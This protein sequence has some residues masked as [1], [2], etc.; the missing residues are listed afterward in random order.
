[1]HTKLMKTV[2]VAIA[3]LALG[4]AAQAAPNASKLTGTWTG[5][6]SQEI[7]IVDPGTGEAFAN[8]W[9]VRM[10]VSVLNGRILRVYTTIRSVCPG[11]GVRDHRIAKK[12][13]IGRGPVVQKAGGFTFR[14]RG[15]SGSAYEVAGGLFAASG[16][17]RFSVRAG[18]CSGKGTWKLKRRI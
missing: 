18:D 14:L 11:P 5:D 7:V 8:E 3:A 4:A 10:T 13:A 6:T 2:V 17:G 15:T 12:W 1:M 9:S 16:A